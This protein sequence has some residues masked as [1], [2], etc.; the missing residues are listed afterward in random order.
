ML[1]ARLS[2]PLSLVRETRGLISYNLA[3]GRVL[4]PAQCCLS[5]Q[6]HLGLLVVPGAA[7]EAL[8]CLQ[9]STQS[10]KRRRSIGN[11]GNFLALISHLADSWREACLG[12]SLQRSLEAAEQSAAQPGG[13]KCSCEQSGTVSSA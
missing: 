13:S 6:Q 7:G 3:H 5:Q 8:R 10:V 12:L 11:K 1:Q 4:G 2:F 9:G